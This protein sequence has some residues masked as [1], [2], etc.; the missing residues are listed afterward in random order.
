MTTQEIWQAAKESIAPKPATR[1]GF[2]NCLTPEM[3]EALGRFGWEEAAT[4]ECREIRLNAYENMHSRSEIEDEIAEIG[5]ELSDEPDLET[6][7]PTDYHYM[8]GYAAALRWVVGLQA[9]GRETP[10]R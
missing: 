8:S 9:D 1:R 5:V 3:I 6:A 10:V 7:V 4:R 2:A